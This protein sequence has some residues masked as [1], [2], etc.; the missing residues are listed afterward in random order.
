MVLG[1]RTL[2][3]KLS[4]TSLNKKN[5]K[6]NYNVFIIITEENVYLKKYNFKNLQGMEVLFT[7]KIIDQKKGNY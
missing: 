5:I 4:I 2:K 7:Q 1:Y 6:L 3:N